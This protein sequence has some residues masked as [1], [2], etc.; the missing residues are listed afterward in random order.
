V[1]LEAIDIKRI[2][3]KYPNY[4]NHID[5]NIVSYQGGLNDQLL[6]LAMDA[7]SFSRFKLDKNL[8]GY[9]K[10]MYKTWLEKSISRSIADEVFVYKEEGHIYGFITITKKHKHAVIG[11]I[12]VDSSRKKKGIGRKLID[13]AEEWA[14]NQKIEKITVAT[15]QQNSGACNFYSKLGFEIYDEDFIYHVWDDDFLL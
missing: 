6:R 10:K 3:I 14:I 7:G 13:A 5:K 2:Y 8:S 1:N 9:F 15:Q 11:L 12:A 4:N